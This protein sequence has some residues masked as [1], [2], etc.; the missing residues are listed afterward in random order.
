VLGGVVQGRE[1]GAGRWAAGACST[2][3]AHG[4]A[5]HAAA[6][7]ALPCAALRCPCPAPALPPHCPAPTTPA[8]LEVTR[9]KLPEGL[10]VE[11][12]DVDA[13]RYEARVAGHRNR[14]QRAL[15]AIKD[16]AQD[17]R[18]QLHRQRLHARRPGGLA[19]ARR[20]ARHGAQAVWGGGARA[21]A[22]L[23]PCTV[24]RTLPLRTTGSPTVRPDVSSYTCS[25][26]A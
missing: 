1:A 23:L 22:P 13:A 8:Y 17:A 12:G 14:L 24:P 7:P 6:R 9:V 4:Q 2:E 3:P 5:A 15:D 21:A 16:V 25:G 19:G 10:A 11:G 20:R 26:Q 18:R